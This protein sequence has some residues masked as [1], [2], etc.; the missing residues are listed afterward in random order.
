MGQED[1]IL[2]QIDIL[3]RIIGKILAD[4]LGVKNK[5]EIIE[6]D[7]IIEVLKSELDL[8]LNQIF[9]LNDEDLFTFLVEERKFTLDN[10]EKMAEIF[11][12]VGSD[13]LKR[14]NNS[15]HKYLKKSLTLLEYINSRDSTYSLGRIKKIEKLK[16]LN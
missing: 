13:M 15:C 14:D 7:S 9:E 3:S 6:I 12:V 8:D 1:Y 5:G 10:L 11:F 4:L 2:R 16:T